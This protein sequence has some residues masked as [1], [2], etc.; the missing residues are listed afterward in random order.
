VIGE[1]IGNQHEGDPIM[2]QLSQQSLIDAAKA[3]VI[4]YGNKDWA[5]V[6]AAIASS[7]V[8]DE[9]ATHRKVQGV[10]QVTALWQG[11]ATAL[12]DSK[13]TFHNAV[14]SGD[15]VLLEVTWSGTHT[16]P[17]QT[18]NG[19]LAATGKRIELRACQVFQVAA[20]KAQSM[21]QYFDMATLMQQLGVTP[22]G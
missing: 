12:P 1:G 10:E 15:T 21:R 16:G 8:Y 20:G 18:A 14:V 7:F 2:A 19:P 17:L 3:P 11:W 13:A 6:K 9:V 4:A 5:A 22:S